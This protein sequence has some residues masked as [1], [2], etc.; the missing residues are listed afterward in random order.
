MT[1]AGAFDVVVIGAGAPGHFL[2]VVWGGGGGGRAAARVLARAGVRGGGLEARERGGGRILTVEDPGGGLPVDVGAEFIH[3]RA[4]PTLALLKR[5]GAV[6]YDVLGPHL[7]KSGGRMVESDFSG[8]IDPV[9]DRLRRLGSKDMD[10]DS[11]LR[12]HASDLDEAS[13]KMA[14]SFVE[15]F[16]AA[17]PS[18]VSAKSIKDEME[19]I[20]DVGE[21]PQMRIIG[22]YGPLMDLLRRE[23]EVAGA[24]IRLSCAV[25]AV[26]WERG[27]V[28]V[29]AEEREDSRVFRARAAVVTLPIGVLKAGDVRFEPEPEG[30]HDA[31]ALIE[32]GPV[33]KVVM[34]F[35]EAFWE[36]KEAARAA[37]ADVE[38][39]RAAS[40][41]HYP[42]AAFPTWWTCVP[43]RAPVLTA[44]AGGPRAAALSGRGDEATVEAAVD[45]LS[46]MLGVRQARVRELLE[47]AVTHDWPADPFARGAYSYL[48][49]GGEKARE[50]LARPVEG[51]LW[52]AG[53]AVDTSGQASTVAGAMASGAEAASAARKALG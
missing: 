49:V 15:G 24:V 44:W 25:R 46:E 5:A 26:R 23:A 43:L 41:F 40:F 29:D 38:A 27:R 16:D 12:E 3:G 22:G 42:E 32:S 6:A 1:D 8:E 52:F 51:T 9:M 47:S 20:G 18:R 33:I 37:G 14:R 17:D 36:E 53:E 39:M 13:K 21:Q 30:M 10:F 4:E 31:L 45:T 50:K 2:W 34:R 19:G 7:R 28:E 48:L 11:F 35:R